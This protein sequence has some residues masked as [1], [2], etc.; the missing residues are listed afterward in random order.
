MGLPTI[1]FLIV[2]GI[3][4]IPTLKALGSSRNLTDEEKNDEA[5]KQKLREGEGFFGTVGRILIGDDRF[6]NAKIRLVDKE[7]QDLKRQQAKEAGFTSVKEFEFSTDT[8]RDPNKFRP[9]DKDGNPLNVDTSRK[10][11]PIKIITR[12]GGQKRR[13][14]R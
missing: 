9:K 13:F 5:K 4:L 3:V 8:N 14:K 11:E 10:N 7:R 1:L 6:N 2:A 12:F